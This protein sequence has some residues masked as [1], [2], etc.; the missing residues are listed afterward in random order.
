LDEGDGHCLQKLQ[1][2][3]DCRMVVEYY[4]A[5]YPET[6]PTYELTAMFMSLSMTDR[7]LN[8]IRVWPW[9]KWYYLVKV[10]IKM[11]ICICD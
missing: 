1:V 10:K 3:P 4:D 5:P 9:D 7:C 6:K 8:T 2:H 11:Q